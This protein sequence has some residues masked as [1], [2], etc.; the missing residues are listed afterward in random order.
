MSQDKDVAEVMAKKLP[1][2]MEY[3]SRKDAM[4][5]M[6]LATLEA[7]GHTV[8]VDG[9]SSGSKRIVVRCKCLFK[10]PL[11]HESGR[12]QCM[13]Y[14]LEGFTCAQ[15]I[16]ETDRHYTR[17]RL[18]E[19]ERFAKTKGFCSF[20]AVCVRCK[21]NMVSDD[22]SKDNK[23]YV[24][25]W[26]I[27]ADGKNYIPHDEM[28]TSVGKAT[29]PLLQQ[30]MRAKITVNRHMSRK[31]VV[32]AMTGA[33]SSISQANLPSKSAIYRQQHKIKHEN[34]KWYNF[35]FGRLE[36]YTNELQT[37]NTTWTVKLEKDDQNHFE[38]LF[39]GIGSN[40]KVLEYA[41][42][43][44][45]ALDSCHVKHLV[46]K[47]LQLH[48]L[49]ANQGNNRTV[50]LAFSVDTTKSGASYTFFGEQCEALGIKN[51]FS[52]DRNFVPSLPVL[53][54]DGMKGI[55]QALSVWG[56]TIH[57]AYCARHLA[58]SIRDMLKRMRSKAQ[59][60]NR[61][62]LEG[63]QCWDVPAVTL[64]DAQMY[65][66]CRAPS[67]AKF[68]KQMN[69]LAQSN[70]DAAKLL[71]KKDR[72]RYSQSAMMSMKPKPVRCHNKIT[73][74]LVEGTN[75]V[76][77]S[78]RNED[79]YTMVHEL[80]TYI[81]G[82]FHE[83]QKESQKLKD[84]DK[85]LTPYASKL[86]ASQKVLAMS[87]Q[88]Y[89]VQALGSDLYKVQDS[90]SEGREN[91]TVCINKDN[92]SCFPCNFFNQHGIPCRHM[93]LA[94]GLNKPE[95][96]HERKDEFFKN[97]FHPSFFVKNLCF[98]Y[99]D[100]AFMVPN[101][102]MGPPLPKSMPMYDSEEEVMR[103]SEEEVL[104]LPPIG[105]SLDDYNKKKPRGRPRNKRI[106]SRGAVGDDGAR[107]RKRSSGVRQGRSNAQVARDLLAN[108]LL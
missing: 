39:I 67:E 103:D 23:L 12:K 56:D 83:Q 59:E 60:H 92:P 51:L 25:K 11:G 101:A 55:E 34:L 42:L 70:K 71:H 82:K 106:R 79:P 10:L 74:G 17:R 32:A 31:Q 108:F 41:G 54:S 81:A 30:I 99:E 16:G 21:P 52:I 6:R 57:H 93:M 66:V 72:T 13:L 62:L 94:I 44:V 18:A 89:T 4:Q 26:I 33:G 104:M 78:I 24:W 35:N 75:G 50:I 97:F 9:K 46:A 77:V 68:R 88:A 86:F 20:K 40:I 100:G 85:V 98:G 69:A 80:I 15:K 37:M 28:C 63:E 43:D 87:N 61:K 64:A 22:K 53:F 7:T 91:H 84:E 38:R 47:G 107:L 2:G 48:I 76:L 29:G 5:S 3:E 96:L 95:L 65:A 105:F 45:Y 8:A 49:V 14:Q 1:L 90:M 19:A 102:P 27:M 73:S 58:G 36:T